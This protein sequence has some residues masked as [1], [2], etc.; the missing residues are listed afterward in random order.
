MAIIKLDPREGQPYL[1][2]YDTKI[3]AIHSYQKAINTSLN[4]GWNIVYS[5]QP[6][7]G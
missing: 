6:L 4:R 2:Q 1:K 7:F 5:G 3:E